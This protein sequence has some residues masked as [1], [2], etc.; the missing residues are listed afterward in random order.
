[1]RKILGLC[2]RL[3]SFK[4]IKIKRVKYPISSLDCQN[5]FQIIKFKN[6]I[7]IKYMSKIDN[8]LIVDLSIGPKISTLCP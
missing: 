8:I 3:T 5:V 6:K 7:M 2:I 4:N 1:M